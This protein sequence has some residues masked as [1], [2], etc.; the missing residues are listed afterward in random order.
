MAAVADTVSLEHARKVVHLREVLGDVTTDEQGEE[1]QGLA[2]WYPQVKLW[3]TVRS[4]GGCGCG[5]GSPSPLNVEA[6]DFIG[7]HYWVGERSQDRCSHAELLD[8]DNYRAGF[9]LTV[10]GLE[11]VVRRK[12]GQT[13]PPRREAAQ[14]LLQPTPAVVAALAYLYE[15]APEIA[16]DDLLYELVRQEAQRLVV[17][18]RGMLH[19]SRWSAGRG[20]CLHCHMPESVVSDEDRAVCINPWCRTPQGERYC[21]RFLGPEDVAAALAAGVESPGWLEPGWLAVP[22]PDLRGRGQ[23]SDEQLSRWTRT[24]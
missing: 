10:L 19:G 22:E 24:G 3:P 16:A 6:V 17:R 5:A 18:A 2:W 20:P 21:W 4:V 14:H 23:V 11:R 13:E 15:F 8:E 1:R 12:L 7:G 9:E